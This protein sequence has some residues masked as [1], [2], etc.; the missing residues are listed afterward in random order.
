MEKPKRIEI[1]CTEE[2]KEFI[3]DAFEDTCPFSLPTDYCGKN[4]SCGLCIKDNIQFNIIEI[5]TID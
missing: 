1:T 4:A 5:G 3:L 2:D